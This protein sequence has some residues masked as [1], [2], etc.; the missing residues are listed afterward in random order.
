MG[1]YLPEKSLSPVVMDY[2]RYIRATGGI[3]CF[4]GFS[5]RVFL[6]CLRMQRQEQRRTQGS[7]CLLEVLVNLKF[8]FGM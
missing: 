8:V 6:A 4:F 7:P 3:A 1:I 5:A 2:F